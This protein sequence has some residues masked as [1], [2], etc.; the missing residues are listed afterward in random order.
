[1]DIKIKKI[2]AQGLGQGYVGNSV[3][4]QVDRAGFTLETS[5]YLGDEGKYHDEW[6]AHQNGAG[7]ELVKTPNGE[8]ASR[9]YAGGT[10][11]KEGLDKLGI[12]DKDV[13]GKLIFF[14]N[15]LG[16]KTRL[17]VDT[18]SSEGDWT[19][20]YKI[21]EDVNEIPLVIGKEEIKY[22][23]SLVFIHFHINSPVI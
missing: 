9:V 5:D 6:A 10:L 19:Y 14:V 7:Q 13:I 3:R 11:S 4:G 22:K 12:T 20:T 15:Q 17:D 18:E 2:L 1:M 21:L 8:K 16:E 23:G